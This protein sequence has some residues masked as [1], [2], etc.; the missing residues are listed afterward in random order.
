VTEYIQ[1]EMTAEE[2][3]ER[4]AWEAAAYDRE[5]AVVQRKR[6]EAYRAEADYLFF[7][8]ERGKGTKQAWI[9]KVAEIDARY[10]YPEKPVK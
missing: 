2:I 1:R 4:E 7:Y 9:D 3:A 8:A 6:Q 5:V 10:P